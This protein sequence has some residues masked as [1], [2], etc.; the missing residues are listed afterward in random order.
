MAKTTTKPASAHSVRRPL[1]QPGP[2]ARQTAPPVAPVRQPRPPRRRV[3]ATKMGF[4]DHKRRRVGDVFDLKRPG[5]FSQVWMTEVSAGT[6]TKETGPKESLKRE[7]DEILGGRTE[8][9]AD[10]SEGFEVEGNDNA[11]GLEAGRTDNPLGE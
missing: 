4:Y 11:E 9:R 7:H 3:R 1:S 8:G 5:D 10:A 2:R 6:P